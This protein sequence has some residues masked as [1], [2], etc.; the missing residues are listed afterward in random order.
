MSEQ[1][2]RPDHLL[3]AANEPGAE[4]L[5]AADSRAD[6]EHFT[7]VRTYAI[8]ALALLGAPLAWFIGFN[9]DYLLVRSACSSDTMLPLHLVTVIA[10]TLTLA[11]GFAAH[12]EWR[13]AGGGWPGAAD[14]AVAR[15]RFIGVLGMLAAAYFVLVIGAEWLTKLFLD[16]CM[17][18]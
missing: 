13:R 8:Q 15:T 6:E 14:G 9:L 1:E 4:R 3:E 11:S 7:N 12:H 5:L 17:A 2:H 16:P 18:L 10:I